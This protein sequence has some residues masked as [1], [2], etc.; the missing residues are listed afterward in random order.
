MNHSPSGNV[1]PALSRRIEIA[2]AILLGVICLGICIAVF[3]H[4]ASAQSATLFPPLAG[5]PLAQSTSTP[6]QPA[7]KSSDRAT[8]Q[9][10]SGAMETSSTLSDT[11]VPVN[12]PV[13]LAKRLLQ[14]GNI[15]ESSSAPAPKYALGGTQDFWVTNTQ[16]HETTKISAK[17]ATSRP[18]LY[19]WIQDGVN[20]TEKAVNDLSDD[21]ENAIYPT[22]RNIF[23]SEWSPGIDNDVHLHI[24]YARGLGGRTAGY[25]S[26]ADEV[27]PAVHKFS[28]AKEMFVVSADLVNLSSSYIRST[29]AHEFQHMIHWRLDRNEESWVNE[30]F[31]ELAVSLN[32]YD[33]GGFETAFLVNPDMQLNEWPEDQS[34]APAHYGAGYLFTTYF[35]DRFGDKATQA[36]VR[37]PANGLTS[38]ES[39]LKNINAKSPID[40]RAMSGVDFFQ[41]WTIANYLG[42]RSAYNG[43]YAYQHIKIPQVK[44]TVAETECSSG[45]WKTGSVHQFGVDYIQ[46]KCENAATLNFNGNDLV[47]VMPTGP[48]SGQYFYWSNR[49]DESNMS[50]QHEFDL[51]SSKGKLDLRYWTWYD[52]EQDYDYAYVSASTNGVDWVQLSP[53]LCSTDNNS[54]N[55]YGCGYSGHSDGWRQET[56]SLD[57]FAGKKVMVRFDYVTDAAVNG[58]GFLLDAVSLDAIDYKNDFEQSDPSWQAD[59]FVRIQNRLPQTYVLAI[60]G[61]K[62]GKTTIT[63]VSLDEAQTGKV[64][65]E[66]KT[67]YTLVVS[68]TERFTF[69]QAP[70]KYA[71][72]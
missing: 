42:D 19:F 36:L 21:F 6:G 26:S 13:A 2:T 55:N 16:T 43:V 34:K 39:V 52:I 50:L 45:S 48:K 37:D 11:I 56:V 71:I 29:L 14:I 17:L 41:D 23:G 10:M 1:K 12:D 40:G 33:P 20:F 22:D 44:P 28:N 38:V 18:H 70:Y 69:D 49:G 58:R 15:S 66:A 65:L 8:N 51:S 27:P 25:F 68:A 72:R 4:F 9:Q 59:G 35:L 60:I 61:V 31:S 53:S 47:D 54:G 62:D 24:L 64:A 63:R 67:L 30:G 57:Q 5:F 7:V 32:G 46:I 3:T